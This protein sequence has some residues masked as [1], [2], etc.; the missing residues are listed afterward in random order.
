MVCHLGS[1]RRRGSGHCQF[2]LLAAENFI[3]RSSEND[4]WHDVALVVFQSYWLE[5]KALPAAPAKNASPMDAENGEVRRFRIIARLAEPVIVADK[6]QVANA[7]ETLKTIPG[8][9]LLGALANRTAKHTQLK[10][11]TPEHKQFV[12]MFFRGGVAVTGLLP[13]M[14][15]S[16]LY[17]SLKAPQSWA[18]CELHP[19]FTKER[20]QQSHPFHDLSE[21]V[22]QNKCSDNTCD[23]QL[24]SVSGFINLRGERS[25]HDVQTSEEIHITMNRQTGRVAEG[26]LYTYQMIQAGQ[27]FIGE[28]TCVP[29]MWAELQ[30][31]TGLRLGKIFSI[32]LGKA[33]RRGYGLTHLYLEEMDAEE[34]SSWALK[35]LSERLA[36]GEA[37]TK[38]NVTMLFLTDA[39]LI[40][41]WGRFRQG[42]DRAALVE[43]LGVD[44]KQVGNEVEAFVNGRIVDSFN[45]HRQMPRWRDEAITAG[46]MVRFTLSGLQHEAMLAALQKVEKEGIGLRRQE[47][48]GCVAFNHPIFEAQPKL[49]G[50]SLSDMKEALTQ[51]SPASTQA[52]EAIKIIHNELDYARNTWQKELDDHQRQHPQLW[53]ETLND[54][55]EP[56]AR[57]IYLYRYR[58]VTDLLTWFEGNGRSLENAQNLWGDHKLVGRDEQSKLDEA[59]IKEVKGLLQKLKD[60][61]QGHQ[62]V[63]MTL[64]A[65]RLG[66]QINSNR[67]GQRPKEKTNA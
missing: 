63:G 7:F 53:K 16:L 39:I 36:Q 29:G 61:P 6:S 44:E 65:S 1:G 27:W 62:T 14:G 57:L 30:E 28:L 19:T 9:V 22:A 45:T 56:V 3:E 47:G 49:D 55:Y 24:K 60:K 18:Q 13:A 25:Y 51:L 67:K 2:I 15:E 23:G 59:V 35:S 4:S 32:R 41:R 20:S 43:L 8:T 50:I 46:S 48:F 10:E 40:D 37:K 33:T 17:P 12:K 42:I 58:S 38:V 31:K 21:T 26:N 66:E 11:G 54:S 52:D 5:G 34:P 64:L